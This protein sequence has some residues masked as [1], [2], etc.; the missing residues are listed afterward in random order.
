MGSHFTKKPSRLVE[1]ESNN[2]VAQILNAN[3][4]S[5]AELISQEMS[6]NLASTYSS[7]DAGLA[8]QLEARTYGTN[9][10]LSIT[11]GTE[12]KWIDEIG[13]VYG[14]SEENIAKK[15]ARF[16][17][18][19]ARRS[20]KRCRTNVSEMADDSL[21][22]VELARIQANLGP[23]IDQVQFAQ[24]KKEAED[25]AAQ[26]MAEVRSEVAAM[27]IQGTDDDHFGGADVAIFDEKKQN[28]KTRDTGLASSRGQ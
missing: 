7:G 12:T 25:N 22:A 11:P 21:K 2:S 10:D 5:V 27:G 28:F 13:D 26:M 15:E 24:D 18:A 23:I 1:S 9:D 8:R 4:V 19:K 20:G 14:R 16:E 3:N 17:A 6:N